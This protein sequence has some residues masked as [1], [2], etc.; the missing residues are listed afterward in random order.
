MLSSTSREASSP[1]T[2]TLI[3]LSALPD[4]DLPEVIEIMRR[5]IGFDEA[6]LH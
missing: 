1:R 3:L 4:E 6:D 5:M 2:E